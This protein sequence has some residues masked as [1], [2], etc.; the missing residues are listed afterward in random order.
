MHN[1]PLPIGYI[2]VQRAWAGTALAIEDRVPGLLQDIKEQM[3]RE[4]AG[5]VPYG[6][7]LEC[8][9]D[10]AGVPHYTLY[11]GFAPAVQSSEPLNP[12]NL[13]EAEHADQ[14]GDP[15]R[16]HNIGSKEQKFDRK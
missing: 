1:Q 5:L 13:N 14:I 2:E 11:A 15:G 16:D 9:V 6:S 10:G 4:H 7:R 3:A 12:R 8:T